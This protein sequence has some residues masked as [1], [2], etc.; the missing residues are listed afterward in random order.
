MIN[1]PEPER[2]VNGF[3]DGGAGRDRWSRRHP[4]LGHW[5]SVVIHDRGRYDVVRPNARRGGSWERKM[6]QPGRVPLHSAGSDGLPS[7]R[8]GWGPARCPSHAAPTPRPGLLARSGDLA[9]RA[10]RDLGELLGKP[11]PRQTVSAAE[12]GKRAFTAAEL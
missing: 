3:Q 10:R 2:V 7:R 1:R 4:R 12:K 8:A 11:W 6:S 9:P 5:S